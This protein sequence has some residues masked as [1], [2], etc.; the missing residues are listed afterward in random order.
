LCKEREGCG[1]RKEIMQEG[2]RLYK[3]ERGSARKKHYE[4]IGPSKG[5]LCS[6]EIDEKKFYPLS[7]GGVTID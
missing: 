2:R 4:K 1:R 6:V 3:E 7:L 5:L